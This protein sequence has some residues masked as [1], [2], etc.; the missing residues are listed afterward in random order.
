[1]ASS[2]VPL[3]SH[4]LAAVKDRTQIDALLRDRQYDGITAQGRLLLYINPKDGVESHMN[5]LLPVLAQVFWPDDDVESRTTALNKAKRQAVRDASAIRHA[6]AQS[7]VFYM[8]SASR[9]GKHGKRAAQAKQKSHGLSGVARGTLV[10][11]QIEDALLID[12]ASFRNKY[13]S[14]DTRTQAFFDFVEH[15]QNV[16]PILGEFP[17]ADP[18]LGIV[19]RF[20]MI[21]VRPN[22]TI[23]FYEHKNGYKHCFGAKSTMDMAGALGPQLI[24]N[25]RI[26]PGLCDSELNR[27]FIQLAFS[28]IIAVRMHTFIHHFEA[29]VLQADDDP[30]APIKCYELPYEF[31]RE[32]IGAM[33]A[34]VARVRMP[35]KVETAPQQSFDH[36]FAL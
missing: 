8:S 25:G 1:M 34:D 26:H 12:P 21:G 2:G 23:V 27:A 11:R 24:D 5:G 19:A 13:G 20:D 10:H 30:R 4:R 32:R 16:I 35:R 33:Y 18:D 14:C 7:G 6:A 28:V 3:L 22:G 17:V 29:Y 9:R 31:I 36:L 15:E